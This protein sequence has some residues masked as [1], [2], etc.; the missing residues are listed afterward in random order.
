MLE[1]SQYQ[2]LYRGTRWFDDIEGES[3]F[4]VCVHVNDDEKVPSSLLSAQVRPLDRNDIFYER[5]FIQ[6]E[7]QAKNFA[8]ID[9]DP[10][11]ILWMVARRVGPIEFS[12]DQIWEALRQHDLEFRMMYP[13]S[14]ETRLQFKERDPIGYVECMSGM[15]RVLYRAVGYY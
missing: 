14:A 8:V 5:G 11:I 4:L 6:A 2:K 9:A 12:D 13:Q 10:D 15:E 7:V 3:R 1:R